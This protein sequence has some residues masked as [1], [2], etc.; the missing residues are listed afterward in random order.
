MQ[1]VLHP[2]PMIPLLVALIPVVTHPCLDSCFYCFLIEKSRSL[3]DQS[4]VLESV[5]L[6]EPLA[7]LNKWSISNDFLP[8]IVETVHSH[9][10]RCYSENKACRGWERNG[11]CLLE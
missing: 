7:N 5:S 11:S 4:S 9:N 6:Y 2:E 8:D 10:G 1:W 3:S